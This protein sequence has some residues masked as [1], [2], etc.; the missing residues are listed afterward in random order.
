MQYDITDT[1][2]QI[3]IFWNKCICIIVSSKIWYFFDLF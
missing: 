1:T 3:N 2:L